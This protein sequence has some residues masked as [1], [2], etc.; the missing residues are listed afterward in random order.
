MRSEIMINF[1]NHMIRK[2]LSSAATAIPSK[3]KAPGILVV[4]VNAEVK[5][6]PRLTNNVIS[7]GIEGKVKFKIPS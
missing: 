5:K 4:K 6:N 3:A 2:K 1:N 7:A